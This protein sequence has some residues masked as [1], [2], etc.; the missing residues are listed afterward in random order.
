[1]NQT[2]NRGK[3]S[4]SNARGFTIIEML[5]VILIIAALMAAAMPGFI[6]AMAEG[7]HKEC[8]A[9]MKAI[10][11]AQREYKL[12]D[13]G[14]VGHIPTYASTLAILQTKVPVNVQCP[15]TGTYTLS[16]TDSFANNVTVH[17]SVAGHDAAYYSEPAGFSLS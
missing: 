1:M 12:K 9:N 2:S 7:Q 14:V 3:T 8:R 10:A 13:A 15:T 4:R 5:A 11:N 16:S 6:S 17:C